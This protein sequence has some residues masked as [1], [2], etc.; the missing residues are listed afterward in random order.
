MPIAH[1]V[2]IDN[3][4]VSPFV[5][6]A[7]ID[8]LIPSSNTS[9]VQQADIT[10][11]NVGGRFDGAVNVVGE[12]SAPFENK[13]NFQTDPEVSPLSLIMVILISIE[14]P[15]PSVHSA[16]VFTGLAQKADY[17]YTTCKISA[18]TSD[19]K[20]NAYLKQDIF[21]HKGKPTRP[22][23]DRI[24]EQ[25]GLEEGE[26]KVPAGMEKREWGFLRDQSGKGVLDY[27]AENDGQEVFMDEN[28]QLQYVPPGVRGINP[29]YTGRMKYPAQSES[30]VGLCNRVT[31]RG[32]SPADPTHPHA[33]NLPDRAMFYETTDAD[34]AMILNN[35]NG[36][37][38]A[39]V[40]AS[41][42]EN[43]GRIDAPTFYY[44]DCCTELECR[45]RAL[46]L[47]ARYVTFWNRSMPAV[48]GRSPKLKSKVSYKYPR[49]ML[50]SPGEV[51]RYVWALGPEMSGFVTRCKT[52]Y[53]SK[54][55]WVS[56]IEVAP[57]V[58]NEAN[59][60]QIYADRD[61]GL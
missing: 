48:V 28:N 1:Y 16:L 10:L 23:I 27:L 38:G 11:S 37:G 9:Y 55:G 31:V 57:F 36:E 53:S 30:A 8:V 33:S 44:P 22:I 18:G 49:L 58:L 34:L 21:D 13:K 19:L 12:T 25:Y 61:L 2:L 60:A 7:D 46:R 54:A 32:A 47:L 39:E 43:Y 29:P 51:Q 20:A 42:L 6:G 59:S 4:D 41:M 40:A 24:C 35:E 17:G 15:G 56:Y 52:N 14:Y 3:I 45:N 5:M 50:N 26:I